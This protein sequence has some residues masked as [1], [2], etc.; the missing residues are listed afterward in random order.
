MFIPTSNSPDQL[1]DTL[2]ALVLTHAV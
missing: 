2:K 1:T